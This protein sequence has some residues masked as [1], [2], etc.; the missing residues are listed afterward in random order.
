[1]KKFLKTVNRGIILACAAVL[2]VAA[3]VIVDNT[4]FKSEKPK[5]RQAVETYL[6]EVKTVNLAAPESRESKTRELLERYWVEDT[7]MGYYGFKKSDMMFYLDY[8]KNRMGKDPVITGYTE[9]LKDI[10]TVQNGPGGAKVT[11]EYSVS[12]QMDMED[13][14]YPIYGINGC[15]G[16]FGMS[17]PASDG[18]GVVQN[19][20][21]DLELT[22][23]QKDGQW[24]ITGLTAVPGKA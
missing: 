21:Y 7:V 10:K 2:C 18:A 1:M 16:D 11:A 8:R 5:I 6:E 23:R 4:R 20:T 3:Y 13:L 14:V 17:Q 12:L 9:L 24:K 15:D 22:L 19:I